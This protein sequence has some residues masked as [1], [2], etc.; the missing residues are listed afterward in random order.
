MKT[1]TILMEKKNDSDIGAK[2]PEV[3]L[4]GMKNHSQE[5]E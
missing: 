4:K 5:I 1:Q 3:E 2:I